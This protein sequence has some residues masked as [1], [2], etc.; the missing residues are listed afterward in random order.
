LQT[1]FVASLGW[2][3]PSAEAPTVFDFIINERWLPCFR[4][5]VPMEGVALH[6][7]RLGLRWRGTGVDECRLD[8]QRAFE[9]GALAGRKVRLIELLDVTPSLRLHGLGISSLDELHAG[10][11]ELLSAERIEVI[12]ARPG[13]AWSDVDRA[14]VRRLLR[15]V[16]GNDRAKVVLADWRE[17]GEPTKGEIALIEEINRGRRLANSMSSRVVGILWCKDVDDGRRGERV[18][19]VIFSGARRRDAVW[20]TRAQVLEGAAMRDAAK[21]R[22]QHDSVSRG[23][24]N[25]IDEAGAWMDAADVSRWEP[26]TFN[27][28]LQRLRG[29]QGAA[30]LLAGASRA[31]GLSRDAAQGRIELIDV[32]LLDYAALRAKGACARA[33]NLREDRDADEARRYEVEEHVTT[34]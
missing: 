22:V 4:S 33:I 11:G 28:F 6:M 30:K 25:E 16:A 17:R 7:A 27:C 15:E 34:W 10:G 9:R 23:E 31:A 19:E 12:Y 26:S 18:Y 13:W 1:V 24:L 20:L 14:H 5:E 29:P 2:D 21:A 8:T 3:G 32:L